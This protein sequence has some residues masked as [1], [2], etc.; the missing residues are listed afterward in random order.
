MVRAS[1]LRLNGQ[2]FDPWLGEYQSTGTGM[3][4]RLWAGIPSQ[5]VTSHP[6]QR[7]LL[8]PVDGK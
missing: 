8:P 4:G 6:G 2:E 1:D 3:G 5:Y 7:S